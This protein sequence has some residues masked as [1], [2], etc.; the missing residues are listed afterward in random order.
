MVLV[1]E[2]RVTIKVGDQADDFKCLVESK[3]TDPPTVPLFFPLPLNPP[4]S[5]IPA[6]S[7]GF[8]SISP[9]YLSVPS[10]P[11]DS[12]LTLSP[13]SNAFLGLPTTS[14]W[15][16][17]GRLIRVEVG[18]LAS[19]GG[20]ALAE[21]T[22]AEDDRPTT[23]RRPEVNEW[24]AD[25]GDNDIVELRPGCGMLR[26]SDG[27]FALIASA[28]ARDIS[29]TGVVGLCWCTVEE[30]RDLPGVGMLLIRPRMPDCLELP[31]VAMSKTQ[32][33]QAPSL[34]A[35]NSNKFE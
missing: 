34:R 25:C 31:G 5:S 13:T 17:G 26:C 10:K 21:E 23:D 3:I 33:T 14:E 27:S 30:D 9:R 35:P 19:D 7:P 32:Y 11:S 22:E 20:T 24:E 15:R 18:V 16:L 4:L 2:S 8:P 28:K 1:S 6:Q 12:I 29:S